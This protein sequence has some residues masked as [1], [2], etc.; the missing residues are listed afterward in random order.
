MR[1]LRGVLLQLCLIAALA[2]AT[3]A[4]YRIK[5]HGIHSA[6]ATREA[7]G[8]AAG[9]AFVI[10]GDEFLPDGAGT[11]RAS[12]PY[13]I[14]LSGVRVYII[15][16]DGE[17]LSRAPIVELTRTRIDALMPSDLEPGQYLLAIMREGQSTEAV[18]IQVVERNLGIVTWTRGE[19]G[20]ALAWI[21]RG[22]DAVTNRWTSPAHP[23][24]RIEVQAAGLGVRGLPG[25]NLPM[26]EQEPLAAEVILGGQAIP[27]LSIG[28]D[29][30]RPG[31]DRIVFD[32]PA[33]NIPTGCSV[34]FTVRVGNRETAVATL[35]I[36]EAGEESCRHPFG[37]DEKT[38]R[39]ID[40]G[41]AVDLGNFFLLNQTIYGIEDPNLYLFGGQFT[42]YDFLAVA[43]ETG[44]WTDGLFA[45]RGCLETAGQDEHFT[46]RG[47]FTASGPQSLEIVRPDGGPLPVPRNEH[48]Y[49]SSVTNSPF[50]VGDYVLRSQGDGDTAVPLR[51]SPA[52]EWI[53]RDEI[54]EVNRE[55]SLTVRWLG[56]TGDEVVTVSVAARGISPTD[57]SEIV[58]RGYQCF[59]PAAD[60]EI[61]VPEALLKRLP[62]TVEGDEG[63]YGVV[64]VVHSNARF[65]AHPVS[66]SF[67]NV[68]TRFLSV[69]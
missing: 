32:L 22:A 66:F 14:E 15:H 26:P 45:P 43:A 24:E 7:D 63:T 42:R 31:F 37:F 21:A 61:V 13:P 17:T 67:A 49:Y 12:Q 2:P 60:G 9:S 28:R 50:A 6:A 55:E 54:P 44:L 36:T 65:K 1:S 11:V 69:K 48:G 5:D 34:G 29:L 40:A 64:S 27:V 38:L 35:A 47:G 41:G 19:A 33:E 25:T 53:N 20:L 59:A 58:Q 39:H 8:I 30:N 57:P 56:G 3:Q 4:Q 68:R 46:V 62:A 18:D 23:G 51:V 16:A 52:V 10:H